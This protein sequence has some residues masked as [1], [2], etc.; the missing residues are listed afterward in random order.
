MN[1]LCQVLWLGLSEVQVTWKLESKIPQAVIRE[2]ET[3]QKVETIQTTTSSYGLES[4]KLVTTASIVGAPMTKM[5]RVEE[6]RVVLPQ[7]QGI[8][9]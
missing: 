6:N 8:L 5:A 9:A 2:F 1:I 4:S 3:D 7:I